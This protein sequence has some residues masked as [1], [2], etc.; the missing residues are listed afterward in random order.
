MA[1]DDD[2]D[3]PD[4]GAVFTFG[5]S[6]FADNAP[7][8]FWIKNDMIVEIA[9]GD[10]HTAVLT[11]SGR[12]FTI[13]NND[14]GQLGLGSKRPVSKPS[15]VKSLKPEKVVHIG[16]GRSHT[17]AACRECLPCCIYLVLFT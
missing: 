4:T 6:R 11:E 8:K 13:G 16:C 9:C 3:I 7:S 10:E 2:F 15:C 17:I 1:V 12:V 5:R 14:M